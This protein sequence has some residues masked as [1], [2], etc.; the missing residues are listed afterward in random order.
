[1]LE[2]NSWDNPHGQITCPKQSWMSGGRGQEK[3]I[4]GRGAPGE[5]WGMLD[6]HLIKYLSSYIGKRGPPLGEPGSCPDDNPWERCCRRLDTEM[7]S[8]WHLRV[9]I[10]FVKKK[11]LL[12]IMV[13]QSTSSF[14]KLMSGP[15]QNLMLQVWI[16]STLHVPLTKV[17]RW[18]RICMHTSLTVTAVSLGELW[19]ERECQF[20]NIFLNLKV[21]WQSWPLINE[22]EA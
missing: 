6:H 15:Q 1:M 21:F 2:N 20:Y 3:E 16:M 8:L 13:T 19:E 5:R 11:R 9:W 12:P 17:E 18:R 22:F 4:K 10:T 14:L 7:R